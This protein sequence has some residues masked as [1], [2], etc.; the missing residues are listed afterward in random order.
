MF[1]LTSVGLLAGL[2]TGL[3][4]TLQLKGQIHVFFSLSLTL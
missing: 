4:K 1:S 2:T 3:H